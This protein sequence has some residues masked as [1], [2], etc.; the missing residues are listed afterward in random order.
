[1]GGCKQ[2]PNIR[3]LPANVKQRRV[4]PADIAEILQGY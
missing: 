2:G 4:T 1:L 3:I